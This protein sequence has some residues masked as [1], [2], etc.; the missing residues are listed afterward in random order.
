M[1]PAPK[2]WKG[3]HRV[4]LSSDES[5]NEPNESETEPCGEELPMDIDEVPSSEG[6]FQGRFPADTPITPPIIGVSHKQFCDKVMDQALPGDGSGRE[7]FDT[8]PTFVVGDPS[9]RF[10]THTPGPMKRQVKLGI[11]FGKTSS[12]ISS[13]I[14]LT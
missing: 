12:V 10:D 4:S 1:S 6:P 3:F 5:E 2:G 11:P 13:R 9:A 7:C 14:V 8:C